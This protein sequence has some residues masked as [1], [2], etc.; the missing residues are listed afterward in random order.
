MTFEDRL[1]AERTRGC[2][3]MMP[4]TRSRLIAA[5]ACLDGADAPT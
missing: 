2:K 3:Q 4:M 5:F 1:A